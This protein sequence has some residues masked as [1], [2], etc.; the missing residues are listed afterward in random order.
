MSSEY[1]NILIF[2]RQLNPVL[3]TPQFAVSFCAEFMALWQT[4]RCYQGLD[5]QGQGQGLDEG[6]QGQ[7]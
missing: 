2:T 6:V 7:G 5:C 4:Q 3:K 1:L